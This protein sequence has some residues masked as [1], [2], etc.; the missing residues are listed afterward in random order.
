MCSFLT[1]AFWN[2]PVKRKC[3][4]MIFQVRNFQAKIGLSPDFNEMDL[5]LC[6]FCVWAFYFRSCFQNYIF[7]P[8]IF[9]NQACLTGQILVHNDWYKWRNHSY[10]L[11]FLD[12]LDRKESGNSVF[13]YWTFTRSYSLVWSYD[14]KPYFTCLWQS[15]IL[16]LLTPYELCEYFSK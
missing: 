2:L 15:I 13:N 5:F 14:C 16:M 1:F 6:M 12:N 8:A 10:A 7:E 4:S 11:I 3:V 9:A